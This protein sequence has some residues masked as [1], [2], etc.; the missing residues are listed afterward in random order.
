M[1]GRFHELVNA[2]L[3]KKGIQV[4]DPT[5]TYAQLQCENDGGSIAPYLSNI[6]QLVEYY[7]QC[8][9]MSFLTAIQGCRT[10][11]LPDEIYNEVHNET[12]H[13]H[14][15]SPANYIHNKMH[16]LSCFGDERTRREQME[17]S[18]LQY[19]KDPWRARMHYDSAKANRG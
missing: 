6:M 19:S 11:A 13:K 12:V 2:D 3:A 1:K 14:G 9:Q 18:L 10:K 16:K 8:A 15:D 17:A 5:S 4:F 7:A